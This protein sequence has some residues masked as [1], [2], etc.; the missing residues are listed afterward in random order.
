MCILTYKITGKQ[1]NKIWAK[2]PTKEIKLSHKINEHSI[3]Q[4]MG[5]KREKGNK[6]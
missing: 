6:K 5:K 3:N 2:K 4:K 1:N